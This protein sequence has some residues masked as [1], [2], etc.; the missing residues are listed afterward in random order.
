MSATEQKTESK[1]QEIFAFVHG[2][3]ENPS[4]VILPPSVS[5]WARPNQ[6][7]Q[8]GWDPIHKSFEQGSDRWARFIPDFSDALLNSWD[9]MARQAASLMQSD[10]NGSVLWM[11]VRLGFEVADMEVC[12]VKP[13]PHAETAI[14]WEETEIKGHL[15]IHDSFIGGKQILDLSGD[16]HDHQP[17]SIVISG[18]SRENHSDISYEA[19]FNP[20]TNQISSLTRKSTRHSG[21]SQTIKYGF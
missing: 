4:Q 16:L 3:H 14:Y 8:D 13:M 18:S 15:K 12:F 1:A 5:R 9:R 21:G 2:L 20:I 17:M 6:V 7:F 11:P 10:Y 19:I